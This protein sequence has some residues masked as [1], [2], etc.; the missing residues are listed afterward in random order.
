MSFAS[1]MLV[2]LILD[3]FLGW[4]DA[5]Y[6]RIGHPVTWIGAL[7]TWLDKIWNA[8]D[9]AKRRQTGTAAA[10]A[11][12]V[13]TTLPILLIMVLLPNSPLGVML[14]GALAWPMI[15]ARSL[16]THVAAVAKPL[17]DGDMPAARHAVAQIVGRDP[18]QLDSA[19]IARASLESLAENTSDGVIAPLFWGVLFGPGGLW[20]YKAINTLDSM[21]GHWTPRHTDF[22]R[23]AARLDDLVNLAPARLSGGL[24][25]VISGHPMQGWRI[26]ARDA[27]RHRSPNAGWPESALAAALGVRL[28]GPRKYKEGVADEPWLNGHARDPA[29]QDIRRGLALYRRAMILTAALLFGL[30][31]L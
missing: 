20:A 18:D 5:L 10:M 25:A 6:R 26:M 31:V 8:G 4:P 22:G 16:H 2:G 30:S 11:V 3:G 21:I 17:A 12:I 13:A 9:A 1:M 19:G 28:S 14:G 23:F 24:F 15:A 7:I 29:A 27:R